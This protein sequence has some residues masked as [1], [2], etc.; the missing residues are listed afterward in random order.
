MAPRPKKRSSKYRSRARSSPLERTTRSAAA[1]WR[2]SAEL[3]S[4]GPAVGRLAQAQQQ[5]ALEAVPVRAH[6]A[7]IA[8]RSAS[9]SYA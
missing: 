5:R 8:S 2:S 7:S 6:E 4:A 9:S 1:V 3:I